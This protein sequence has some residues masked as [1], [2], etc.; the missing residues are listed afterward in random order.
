M[1]AADGDFAISS[2]AKGEATTFASA[3]DVAC[4]G[5]RNIFNWPPMFTDL[6]WERIGSFKVELFD[7]P[8]TSGD[9][10]RQ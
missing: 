2:I 5:G 10:H 1:E 3:N 6:G 7:G 4:T 9:R 8:H